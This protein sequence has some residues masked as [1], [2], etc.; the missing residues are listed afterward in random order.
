MKYFEP[1]GD[2]W[3]VTD[4][5][6][7]M[8]HFAQGNLAAESAPWGVGKVDVVFCRNVLIYFSESK[9]ALVIQHF[10]DRLVAG[11]YLFL[12]HS[13]SLLNVTTAF[14]L[15]HLSEDLAYRKPSSASFVEGGK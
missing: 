11:G 5:V 14:E 6:K 4:G 8:C 12:G 9:R 1:D 15:A 10:Y 7:A 2:L 13:E 3:R